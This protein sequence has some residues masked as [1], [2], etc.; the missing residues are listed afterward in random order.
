MIRFRLDS[1]GV[2]FEAG[3]TTNEISSGSMRNHA[4]TSL[5]KVLL[6]LRFIATGKM[7]LCN[8]D[9]MGV[10]QSS[11]SRAISCTIRSLFSERMVRRFIKYPTTPDAIRIGGFPG[12][13]DAIDGTHVQIIAPKD[14][15][16]EFVNRH[17]YHSLNVQVVF[18]AQYKLI[19]IIAKWPGSTHD[20]RILSDSGLRVLFEK[21]HIPIHTHLLGDSGYPSRRWLLTPFRM[22]QPGPQTNY[23]R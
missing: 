15:E 23:N 8:G 1:N 19:D 3:L 7:Q 6:I 9:D 14:N 16:N 17:H 11:V 2:N 18:D 22:P 20:A 13:V 5:E 12:I 4:F 10:S 21:G